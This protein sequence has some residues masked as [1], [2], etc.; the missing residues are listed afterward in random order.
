[1]SA[2]SFNDCDTDLI[3]SLAENLQITFCGVTILN[4]NIISMSRLGQGVRQTFCHA[5][6]LP[7]INQLSCGCL[8]RLIYQV[9]IGVSL[10]PTQFRLE[11][12]NIFH[13]ARVLCPNF[14]VIRRLILYFIA[15]QHRHLR[16]LSERDR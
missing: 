12:F 9:Q 16:R 5:F 6:S 1:M 8:F 3:N 11:L 14:N 2:R 13:V 15:N 4:R 7:I 10:Y